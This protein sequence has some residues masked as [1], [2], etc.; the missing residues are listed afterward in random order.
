MGDEKIHMIR[1][2]FIQN[3]SNF[4][5]GTFILAC[6]YIGTPKPNLF[7]ETI[8]HGDFT[9]KVHE[10]WGRLGSGK[11]PIYANGM[12]KDLTP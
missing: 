3:T 5:I 11:Y 8:G 6:F 9:Y 10:D 4:A 7:E 1:R 2:I 12:Q